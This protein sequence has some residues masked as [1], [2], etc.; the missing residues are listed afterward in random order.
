MMTATTSTLPFTER[1]NPLT[2][3]IDVADSKGI[4]DM[5]HSCDEE[6]LAGSFQFPGLQDDSTVR[7]ILGAV[8]HIAAIMQE[9]EDCLVVMSGCGTSGRMAFLA[10]TTCNRL[11]RESGRQACCAYLIAGGDRALLTSQ[12]APEDD[13]LLGASEL[14]Q[15]VAGK[16]K[17]FYIGITCGLS[18]PYVAGQLDY[19][20]QHLET[21]T[22]LLM[23]FNPVQLARNHGIE[24][25]DKTVKDVVEEMERATKDNKAFILNPVVG[26]EPITGST[27]MKGGSATKILLDTILLLAAQ[28]AVDQCA[29]NEHTVRA[30]LRA[31]SQCVESVYS[32]AADISCLV[33]NAGKSLQAS[34]HIYYFGAGTA[35]IMGCIDA[36]ECVP[37]YGS[38]PEDVRG[39]LR[40]G[41]DTLN[42]AD[43]CLANLGP[44]YRLSWKDFCDNILGRF[45]SSDSAI[46]L[47]SSPDELG[48]CA[49]LA[50]KLKKTGGHVMAV[51]YN[52]QSN[53]AKMSASFSTVFPQSVI[54]QMPPVPATG[55]SAAVQAAVCR[56]LGEF[57][58]KLVCNSVSTGAHIMVGKV[59]QNFMVDV[60]IRNNKLF[61]RAIRIVQ[62]LSDCSD[63]AATRAV[64]SALYDTDDVTPLA[65]INVSQHVDRG[66]KQ[67]KVVPIALLCAALQMSPSQARQ[68]LTVTPVIRHAI[69]AVVTK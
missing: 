67:E 3:N 51:L 27:R 36:S 29:I 34:G 25:W 62:H 22:P 50:E 54:L 52:F 63:A 2:Q 10:A 57:A 7:T 21:F 55:G 16:K 18:A 68:Q 69:S 24:T 26:P 33:S 64:L 20:L 30:F 38:D 61:Y 66:T 5:L 6:M 28:K 23:G 65:D 4:V 49:D 40:G 1:S 37:T 60:Q 39:F 47:L 45:C 13:P 59:F 8:D 41:Y 31:Y 56:R 44:L 42:N 12:E 53:D 11:L 19:C 35:G 15:A 58:L 9:P 17:V 43:G 46:F 32:K 48:P 14:Q